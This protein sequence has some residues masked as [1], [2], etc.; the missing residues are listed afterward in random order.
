MPNMHIVVEGTGG[1][2][3]DVLRRRPIVE[4]PEETPIRVETL[5]GGMVGG[6]PSMA[7]IIDLPAKVVPMGAAHSGVVVLAQTSVKLFQLCAA[8]TL[9][10]YGDLTEGGVL[11]SLYQDKVE[12]TLSSLEECPS[13]HRNIPGSCKYCME[14]GA[15]L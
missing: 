4:M 8:A 12:L 2:F 7:F 3:A 5:D 1:H 6:A 15:R 13:C 11:G 14:C 10:K 9:G